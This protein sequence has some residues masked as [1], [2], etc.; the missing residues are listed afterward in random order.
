MCNNSPLQIKTNLYDALCR[1]S[2][3]V[4]LPIRPLWVDAI[5]LNQDDENEKAHQIPHMG[6][7]YQSASR[8][9]I[10]LGIEE[11]DSSYAL[12]WMKLYYQYIR[13]YIRDG[14]LVTANG[15]KT[16][17]TALYVEHRETAKAH[18]KFEKGQREYSELAAA[19]AA[20]IAEELD[21]ERYEQSSFVWR[22]VE[23]IPALL[24]R[25]W[26]ERVWTMQELYLSHSPLIICGPATIDWTAFTQCL[27][28]PTCG[29]EV[30]FLTPAFQQGRS[31]IWKVYEDAVVTMVNDSNM[32][33]FHSPYN[34]RPNVYMRLIESKKCM[35]PVD[36]VWAIVSLFDRFLQ[37]RIWDANIIDYTMLGKQQYW[38]TYLS[39]MQILFR[40]NPMDFWLMILSCQGLPKHIYLPSWCPD[41]NG[42]RQYTNHYHL[43]ATPARHQAANIGIWAGGS[44]VSGS[45]C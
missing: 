41:F 27:V 29:L 35:E 39:F 45:R 44:W 28:H 20:R 8:T 4:A 19:L 14:D 10:W 21:P 24:S 22:T 40:H 36:R 43:A 16:Y 34:Q 15:I 5:C 17:F 2:D 31:R 42:L 6:R 13:P 12:T 26:F 23:A 1:I 11:D 3:R 32:G 18:E 33:R 37:Q 9:L 30:V 7:I 25:P 38:K